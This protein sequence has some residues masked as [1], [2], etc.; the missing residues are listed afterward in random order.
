MCGLYET[1][2]FGGEVFERTSM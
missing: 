1:A 2:L